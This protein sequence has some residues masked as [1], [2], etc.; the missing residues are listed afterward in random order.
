MSSGCAPVIIPQP[1]KEAFIL[2]AAE[3]GRVILASSRCATDVAHLCAVGLMADGQAHAHFWERPEPGLQGLTQGPQAGL[4]LISPLLK[5]ASPRPGGLATHSLVPLDTNFRVWNPSAEESQADAGKAQNRVASGLG[6]E[7]Q[8]P[9][10][11]PL[12]QGKLRSFAKRQCWAH[13]QSWMGAR[14]QVS[15]FVKFPR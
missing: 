3:E 12:H 14:A 5:A 6:W 9:L 7:L 4:E 2:V 8:A 15:G 1:Q 11:V 10:S 13:R